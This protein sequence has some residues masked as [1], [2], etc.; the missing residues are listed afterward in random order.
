MD[1]ALESNTSPA[2]PSAGR[3]WA[4]KFGKLLLPGASLLVTALLLEAGMRIAGVAPQT[5]TVL[6]TYF[7]YDETTGW[8]GMSEAKSQFTTMNFDVFITHDEHGYRTSGY[9]LPIEADTN[10]RQPVAWVLGDS[11]TW[12]WGI[13]D[14]KTFV[15]HLNKLSTDGTKYRNL[16]HCGFSSVQQYLLL[17]KLFAEGK[18]PKEVVVMFCGNDLSENL[19]AVDQSPGRAYLEVR[20]ETAE[21][22]NHPTPRSGWGFAVWLKNNSLVW[23]HAHFYIRRAS[24]MNYERKRAIADAEAKKAA[25]AQAQVAATPTPAPSATA[26]TPQAKPVEVDPLKMVPHDQIVGLRYIY[27][28]MRDLCAK[29]DVKLRIVNEGLPVV[30]VVCRELEIPCLSLAERWKQHAESPRA[31][32]PIAFKTDPH[33]NEYGHQM[34]GEAIHSELKR[35]RGDE[36]LAAKAGSGGQPILKADAAVNFKDST[37]KVR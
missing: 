17:K 1:A 19:D 30:P 5:A 34:L 9:D 23:N 11:G 32:E 2:A 22:R 6:S 14:G 3:R 10:S 8:R 4:R 28:E 24:L 15:D 7:E 21:I 25:A 12:G 18:K 16:G 20:G 31:A 29:H 33:F 36:Q 35:V 27:R 26:A 13:P 37:K